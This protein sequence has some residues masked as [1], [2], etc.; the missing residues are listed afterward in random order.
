MTGLFHREI[1]G[2]SSVWIRGNAGFLE[3]NGRGYV[4]SSRGGA[5]SRDAHSCTLVVC[6]LLGIALGSSEESNCGLIVT[7]AACP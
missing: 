3:S 5:P 2:E 1:Y 7:R 4:F 6:R